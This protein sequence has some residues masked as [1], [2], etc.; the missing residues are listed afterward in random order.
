MLGL[1]VQYLPHVVGA[2][3]CL[4]QVPVRGRDAAASVRGGR[5]VHTTLPASKILT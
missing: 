1:A 5:T 2:C 4:S 3:L